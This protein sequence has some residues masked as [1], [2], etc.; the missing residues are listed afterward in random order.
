MGSLL[1]LA[2]ILGGVSWWHFSRTTTTPE[3]R[4]TPF[5]EFPG[6]KFNPAFSPDGKQVALSWNGENRENLDIYVKLVGAGGPARLTTHAAPDVDPA[7]SPDGR[8]I[9]FRR[10]SKDS[11]DVLIIPANGGAERKLAFFRLP[12][13]TRSRKSTR[14]FRQASRC[15]GARS[16]VPVRTSIALTYW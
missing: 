3:L 16:P 2:L 7:W 14:P 6:Q 13:I 4:V 9:A 1:S 10:V 8:F 15:V 11:N 5:T 12:W